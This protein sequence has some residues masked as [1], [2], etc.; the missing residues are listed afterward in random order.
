M[1]VKIKG[2]KVRLNW[3]EIVILLVII[4]GLLTTDFP[5]VL[6]FLTHFR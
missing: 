5:T 4:Y 1:K 2:F 3:W 6:G